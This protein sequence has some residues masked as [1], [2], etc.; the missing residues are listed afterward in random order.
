MRFNHE[1]SLDIS[2]EDDILKSVLKEL[3]EQIINIFQ[4]TAQLTKE[5]FEKEGFKIKIKID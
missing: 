3:H 1:I 5:E 4:K 2:S